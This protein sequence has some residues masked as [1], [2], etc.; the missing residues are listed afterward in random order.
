MKPSTALIAVKL[1]HTVAWAFFASCVVAIPVLAWRGQH[2]LALWAASAVAVEVLVLAV[3]GW[4]CPLT[5]I[6][7]RF[8]SDRRPNFDIYLPEWLA[9]Y[10]KEI[11]GS[12]YVLGLLYLLALRVIGPDTP[13]PAAIVTAS[14]VGDTTFVSSPAEGLDGPVTLTERLRISADQLDVGAVSA[15]AFGA[16]GTIWV[17]DQQGRNGETLVVLDSVGTRIGIAGHRGEG[18]GEYQGPA[19]L[20]RM[21]DGSML[22]RVMGTARVLRFGAHGE[23]LATIELP[24][25]AVNGWLVTPDGVGGWYQAAAFEENTPR[26]VGRYGWI[27]FAPTGT[28]LDTVFPPLRFFEEPTPLGIAPGRVRTVSRDGQVLTA[29]PGTSRIDRIASSGKVTAMTW[30]AEAPAYGE[31]ERVDM[32]ELSDR[33]NDLL[34]LVHVPLPARKAAV[35]LIVT[36]PDGGV[37]AALSGTG[38]RLPDEVR[39]KQ[40]DPLPPVKWVDRDRWASFDRDGRLRYVV[41]MPDGV[42]LLDR[43]DTRL[44]GVATATDGSQSLVIW[45]LTTTPHQGVSQ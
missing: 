19:R 44:L 20:F 40:P 7:A 9:R 35:R 11:F 38:T 45:R 24:P 3:S 29:L 42:H 37:W 34:G 27:H 17:Y 36:T 23:T 10:N 39:P 6:A 5:P 18:P 16:N 1:L 33:M 12:A 32:Q 15:A 41:E 30:R 21:S 4:A 2:D 26:R 25:A 22:L 14:I 8:T 43:D 31:Q 13:L 28:V